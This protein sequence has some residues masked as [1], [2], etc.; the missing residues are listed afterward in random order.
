MRYAKRKAV[1]FTILIVSC[2]LII[3]TG[4]AS[5]I[6]QGAETG[7]ASPLEY[8]LDLDGAVS[9]GNAHGDILSIDGTPTAAEY[10]IE[11]S[12]KEKVIKYCALPGWSSVIGS[13]SGGMIYSCRNILRANGSR[14]NLLVHKGN[15]IITTFHSAGMQTAEEQLAEYDDDVNA[16]IC[17]VLRDGAV[18]VS[19]GNN[20]YP[21]EAFFDPDNYKDLYVDYCASR[22]L[23]GSTFKPLTIRML[24]LNNDA[25]GEEYSLYN[26]EF[27]DYNM[28]SVRGNTII[29]WDAYIPENYFTDEG[30][31]LYSRIL[32][33]SEA[34]QLSANTYV[35]RHADKFGLENTYKNL[36]DLYSLDK[37]L[38]TEINELT[39]E[40]V[41]SERLAYF[42]WGQDAD[43]SAVEMCQLY[44]YMAG[45]TYNMP[46]YV[47]CVKEPDGKVIYTA[48]PAELNKKRLDIDPKTDILD[49]ALADCFRSYLSDDQL[50]RYSELVS[51]RRILA[52]S[53]TADLADESVNR[54]MML[55]VLN[56][57]QTQVI[58]TACMCVD[59]TFDYDI[60]NSYMIEKLITVLNSMGIL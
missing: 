51:S 25:L 35:L 55:T 3:M 21:Q 29:N 16:H 11:Y 17:V 41:S 32:S 27:K 10:T 8:L 53:G 2:F 5:S 60:Q 6:V 59:H 12:P 37:T 31:G 7:T 39:V 13:P 26:P 9:E 23:K 36:T 56:E 30:N 58:C 18:L 57:E 43:L 54:V 47:V 15:S 19:Q 38:H 1:V 4:A 14:A 42:P 49:N 40:S 28:V 50:S 34:L 45:G 48:E 44:N 20:N 22:S 33:L 24:L 46:F 52:K